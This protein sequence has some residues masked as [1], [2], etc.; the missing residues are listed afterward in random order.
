VP[1]HAITRGSGWRHGY[2]SVQYRRRHRSLSQSTTGTETAAT[3]LFPNAIIVVGVGPSPCLCHFY[4]MRS[5][6]KNCQNHAVMMGGRQIYGASRP[7]ELHGESLR[8]EQLL[9]TTTFPNR[10]YH[11]TS[12]YPATESNRGVTSNGSAEE[13]PAQN[14]TFVLFATK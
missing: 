9:Y 5:S 7:R 1:N 8:C 4:D 11:Q 12:I 10:I 14:G 2:L 3:E 13:K 6:L